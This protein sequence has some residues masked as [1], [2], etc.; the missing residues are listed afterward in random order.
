ME[1]EEELIRPIK[2]PESFEVYRLKG[3][4][5]TM[6]HLGGIFLNIM[7]S[8]IFFFIG[9]LDSSHAQITHYVKQ[10]KQIET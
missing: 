4:G 8:L 3:L 6:E 7:I 2:P 5:Q 9:L 10:V 1:E